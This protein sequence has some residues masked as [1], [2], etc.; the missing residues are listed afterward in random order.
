MKAEGETTRKQ[1]QCQTQRE[2][3]WRSRQVSQSI[4]DQRR[5]ER[6]KRIREEEER[7]SVDYQHKRSEM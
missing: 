3:L 2:T 6:I 4:F 5:N 7:V 1:Q